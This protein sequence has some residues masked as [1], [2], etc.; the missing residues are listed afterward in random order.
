VSRSERSVQ[1]VV[2]VCLMAAGLLHAGQI[3]SQ[4]DAGNWL[5]LGFF[6]LAVTQPLLG[7][8][9]LLQPAVQL[10]ARLLYGSAVAVCLC[11]LAGY[12]VTRTWS[13]RWLDTT[14]VNNWWQTAGV[15]SGIFEVVVVMLAVAV[16]FPDRRTAPESGR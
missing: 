1:F 11:D 7:C 14:D 9:T 8:V 12:A 4:W 6:A 3:G 10:P 13:I 16:V 5:L 15:A 2:A